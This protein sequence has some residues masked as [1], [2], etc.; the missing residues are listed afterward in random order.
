MRIVKVVLLVCVAG[1]SGSAQSGRPQLLIV[2][3]QAN[4]ETHLLVIDGR[5]FTWANDDQVAVTLA[6]SPL[7]VLNLASSQIQ[8]MLP[9]GIAPGDYLLRVSRGAGAVQNDSFAL[10]L[11]AVGPQ[12]AKG[13]KGEPGE[14]GPP[15]NIALAGRTCPA[16]AFM[17]GFQA[18]GDLACS[19]AVSCS[20]DDGDGFSDTGAIC[21]QVDCDDLA[22]TTFPG[23]AEACDEIDNDCDGQVDEACPPL[24]QADV[25]W[26]LPG[27]G[28]MSDEL[29]LLATNLNAFALSLGSS[30]LD[31]R[32]IVIADDSFC[33]QPPLGQGGCPDRNTARYRHVHTP[34]GSSD[35][36]EALVA[37]Y[38]QY[39]SFLRPG[40]AKHVVVVSDT[41]SDLSASSFLEQVALMDPGFPEGFT[42]HSLVATS[43]EETRDPDPLDGIP[44]C[45]SEIGDEYLALSAATGGFVRSICLFTSG[46]GA[47]ETLFDLAFA[48]DLTSE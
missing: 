33:V 26:V 42:F 10:T 13:D 23:A 22:P 20:D 48:I 25:I 24:P 30:G 11:G 32:L 14:Q 41:D 2:Q 37:N 35:Q 38:S 45:A 31:Y 27:S 29:A 21:G 18:N 47:L 43:E 34:V 5:N 46:S 28:S 39:Q 44:A 40:A 8:V 16:G 1:V 3:A 17:V 15:G 4:V 36:L 19:T 12:G 7:P 6:G 9:E